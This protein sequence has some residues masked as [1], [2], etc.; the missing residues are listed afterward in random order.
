[1]KHSWNK[2]HCGRFI[3]ILFCEFYRKLKGSIFKRCVFGSK[4]HN[5]HMVIQVKEKKLLKMTY[6]TTIHKG[7]MYYW[8]LS[9][10]KLRT[11]QVVVRW[12]DAFISMFTCGI[13]IY[14]Y[15]AVYSIHYTI[16]YSQVTWLHEK[17]RNMGYKM[18]LAVFLLLFFIPTS[19]LNQAQSNYWYWAQINRSK[20]MCFMYFFL[21]LAPFLLHLIVY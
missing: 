14:L 20:T 6:D 1:M 10:S 7:N 9:G 13:Y 3:R 21:S 19:T 18:K 4:N 11:L 2:S 5:Q 17:L 12:T 15:T 16:W 8:W